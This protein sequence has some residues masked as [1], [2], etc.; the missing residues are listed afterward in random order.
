MKSGNIGIMRF[1][2]TLFSIYRVLSGPVSP[3]ISTITD[4]Y[5]GSS[6][7]LLDLITSQKL[8]FEKVKGFPF[9]MRAPTTL[10]LSHKSSPSNRISFMGI[11]SDFHR[12]KYGTF[13]LNDPKSSD[14]IFINIL[15]YLDV[16]HKKGFP[17]ARI[18]SIFSQMDSL[19]YNIKEEGLKL[20]TKPNLAGSGL[21]QFAFKE[22]AAGKLRIFAILDSISQSILRPLHDYLFEI[23]KNIPNDGTFD[24]ESSVKRSTEKL[25]MYGIAYSFDLSAATDRLPVS[26]TASIFERLLNIDGFAEA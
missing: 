10:L 20:N 23:L 13:D 16:L 25:Q 22:E 21:S 19:L 9:V 4:P 11:L 7:F 5:A 1:W 8:F 24:Q 6:S 17:I 14:P 18:K 2:M 12:L 3:K 15:N 26:L